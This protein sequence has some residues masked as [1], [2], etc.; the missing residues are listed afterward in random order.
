MIVRC[1]F[2]RNRLYPPVPLNRDPLSMRVRCPVPQGAQGG[3]D[4]WCYPERADA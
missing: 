2:C 3:N 4:G 1:K